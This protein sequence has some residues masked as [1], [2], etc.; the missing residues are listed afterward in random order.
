M[1]RLTV[2]IWER[3]PCPSTST[4]AALATGNT[5]ADSARETAS[6]FVSAILM[7][8]PKTEAELKTKVARKRVEAEEIIVELTV[9]ILR[10]VFRKVC[11]D[12]D[13]RNRQ[14]SWGNLAPKR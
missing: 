10:N 1:R 13:Q 12:V 11:R 7:G 14:N 9:I 8:A 3:R 6:E 4:T 2:P 5:G